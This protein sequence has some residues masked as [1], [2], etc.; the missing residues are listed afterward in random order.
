MVARNVR[1]LA[2]MLAIAILAACSR[3]DRPV[4]RLFVSGTLEGSGTKVTISDGEDKV[5]SEWQTGDLIYG[6]WTAADG[7]VKP[8]SYNVTS[9][10][11]SGV[12]SFRLVSGTEPS[13]AGTAVH[14]VYAS[15][16]SCSGFDASGK[17]KVDISVQD[18]TFDGLAGR[19]VFSSTATTDGRT[20]HFT[21]RSATAMINIKE[22]AGIPSGETIQ[23]IQF[24]APGIGSAEISLIEGSLAVTPSRELSCIRAELQGGIS[25]STPLWL[26]AVPLRDSDMTASVTTD[27][28]LYSKP[29]RKT[30]EAGTCHVVRKL[31]VGRGGFLEGRFTVDGSGKEALFSRGN[32]QATR[33]DG[34]VTSF[35]F[36][37]HQYD[38][39]ADASS[40]MDVSSDGTFDLF[41]WSTPVSD[42][43]L[44]CSGD[45]YDYSGDFLDWG[46]FTGPGCRTLSDGE[47]EYVLSKRSASTVH[48]SG[49]DYRT[50][51]WGF[52]HPDAR[53][54]QGIVNGTEGLFLLPDSFSLPAGIE[55]SGINVMYDGSLYTG[56]PNVFTTAQFDALETAGAVFLPAGSFRSGA[57]VDVS[58]I[59]REGKYWTAGDSGNPGN[60]V[61]LYFSDSVE[62]I[63]AEG[64]HAGNSVRL[65]LDVR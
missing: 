49:F 56:N 20:L 36:A 9:V 15:G 25:A 21:F 1:K 11:A 13:A 48:D 59:A 30:L 40:Q 33:K 32:L 8:L 39:L 19:I 60:A 24:T 61:S 35:G 6:F 28:N 50:E 27:L 5:R 4:P 47:M 14:M 46:R 22:I 16:N 34:R 64:R 58:A 23:A 26:M 54:F 44:L 55:V 17:A 53:F 45:D 41:G 51:Q 63:S 29:L 52:E 18:G 65:V 62:E 3:D 42:F 7:T 2:V 10:D 31:S 12:A 38:F 43:G 57:D 37:G